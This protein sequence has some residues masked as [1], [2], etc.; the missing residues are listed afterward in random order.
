[1]SC[2]IPQTLQD[3][4]HASFSR[5]HLETTAPLLR[6]TQH[7]DPPVSL[8]EPSSARVQLLV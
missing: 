1:M 2:H 4:A 3:L 8:T 6:P 7:P 5:L